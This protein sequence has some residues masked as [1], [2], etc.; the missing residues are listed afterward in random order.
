MSSTE[1]RDLP[2][3]FSCGYSEQEALFSQE[4]LD[5]M[6]QEFMKVVIM[7]GCSFDFKIVSLITVHV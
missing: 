5:R 2:L 4:Y 6:N 7:G 1:S 3:L